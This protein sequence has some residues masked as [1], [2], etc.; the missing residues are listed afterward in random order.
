MSSIINCSLITGIYPDQLKVAK[1]CPIYKSDSKD[2]FSNYRPISLLP[3][4]SK[5]FEKVVFDRIFCYLNSKKILNDNQYGFR[6][7]HSTYMAILDMQNKITAAM[8]R[9]EYA[10][11]IF[12]DL[13]KAFDT[14]DHHILLKKMQHYGIRGL[15]LS[16]LT[17]YLSNRVQYVV[18]DNTVSCMMQIT[19]GVPQ[20]SILGPLLFILYINDIVESSNITIYTVC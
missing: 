14:L 10:V 13:S 1:V 2:K 7:N 11:G 6:K 19:C 20:A 9:Y 3:S 12:I 18:I 5:I 4:F 17:S 16:W 8:D 15:A